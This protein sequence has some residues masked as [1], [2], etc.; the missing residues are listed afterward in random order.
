M[1]QQLIQKVCV[2]AVHVVLQETTVINTYTQE[3][4]YVTAHR[5]HNFCIPSFILGLLSASIS[6]FL[7]LLII[8]GVY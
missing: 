5:S 2:T 8:N 1:L 6:E 7:S 3:C 4:S